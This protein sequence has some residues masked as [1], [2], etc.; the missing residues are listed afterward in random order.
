[1]S[2]RPT[3]TRRLLAGALATALG[4]GVA[5]VAAPPAAQAVAPAGSTVF[6]NEIHYDNTGTDAGELIEIANPTGGDLAGWSIV[7]Y[8]GSGGA[9]Y[10]TR[11][12]SGSAELTVVSYPSN[13]IQNGSPDGIA[14]VNGTTVEQFLSYEGAFTAVGGPADGQR[15][16]DI[17]V[18][19]TSDTPVGHSLQLTGTGDTYGDFTWAAPATATPGTANNGQTFVDGGGPVD[20]P[21]VVTNPSPVEH[22]AGT[23]ADYVVSG[24]DPDDVI[25]SATVDSAPPAGV[26]TAVAG[27][28]TNTATVTFSVSDAAAA[29]TST[30]PVTF[31]TA[32]GPTTVDFVLTVTAVDECGRL[33]THEIADVQGSGATSPLLGQSVIV[34]GVVTADFQAAGQFG[35]FY[36]GDPTPDTDPLT[37][38]GIRVFNNTTPVAVGDVVRIAGTPAE[39]TSTG[40]I[41]GS[42]TQ[43]GGAA[44]VTDCFV[45]ATPPPRSR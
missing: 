41:T 32:D 29:G 26:T 21:L 10:G 33:P 12:L 28:G 42:E 15:S 30:T 13:G 20:E 35:G 4:A 38:D 44:T 31:T 22:P 39:F 25:T 27:T 43:F 5:A 18:A 23:A 2:A 11:S 36:I 9:A 8:N 45:D 3:R 16:T 14:L 24:T 17:G 7:L 1:L 34:E 6:I 40:R 19:E 37:S